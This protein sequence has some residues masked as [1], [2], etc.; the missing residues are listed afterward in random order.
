MSKSVLNEGLEIDLAIRM[1]HRGA[2]LQVLE[3]ETSLSYDRLARLQKEVKGRAGPKGMLPFSVDWFM[4]WHANVHS[5]LFYSIYRNLTQNS[6][7]SAVESLINAYDLYL[8]HAEAQQGDEPVL[9]FTRAWILLRFFNS[10][11]IQMTACTSCNLEFV[12]HVREPVATF[13]CPLCNPPSRIAGSM[14]PPM[15][16][17]KDSAMG[18][19]RETLLA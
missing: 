13:R 9:S 3:K 18:A 1:I 16:E 8:E 6:K 15:G 10:G 17:R 12:T 14:R 11:M 2:R 19:I 5:S 7:R 4:S